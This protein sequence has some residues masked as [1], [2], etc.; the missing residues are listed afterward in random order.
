MLDEV[1]SQQIVGFGYLALSEPCWFSN[2]TFDRCKQMFRLIDKLLPFEACLYYQILP[3]A[4]EGSCLKLGMVHPDDTA[5][6]DYLRRILAYQNYSLEI[7]VIKAEALQAMLSAYLK[8]TGNSQQPAQDAQTPTPATKHS[9]SRVG[10]EKLHKKSDRINRDTLPTLIVDSPQELIQEI[11]SA[12]AQPASGPT[13]ERPTGK[14]D[15]KRDNKDTGARQKTPVSKERVAGAYPSPHHVY[16]STVLTTLS[17]QQLLKEL[18]RRALS[19]TIDRIDC[20]RHLYEGNILCSRDNVLH[21]AISGLP[22]PVLQ[23]V[24]DELKRIGSLPLMPVQQ[25]QRVE[26]E[27]CYQQESL[28][29]RLQIMPSQYGDEATLQ[30]FRGEA[31]KAYKQQQLSILWREALSIGE[32]LQRKVNQICDVYGSDSL[33]GASS[34]PMLNKEALNHLLESVEQQLSTLSPLPSDRKHDDSVRVKG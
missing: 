32:K 18:L 22:L 2:P 3:L 15:L 34:A 1:L 28:L 8:N 30:V 29:L 23:G 25:H 11:N 17:P 24:I 27:R 9:D 13:Q 21:C 31:L 12:N 16:D 20:E 7:Q 14:S 10:E 19:G 6:L 26:I 33:Q 4:V 5:T